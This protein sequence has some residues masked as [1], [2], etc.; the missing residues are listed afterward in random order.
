MRRLL[1]TPS[2]SGGTVQLPPAVEALLIDVAADGFALYCCGDK[3]APRALVASYEWDDCVD[4]ITI[5][6]FDT[7]TAAR[8]PSRGGVDI[9]APQ[10][11]VG[12]RRPTTVSPARVAGPRAPG[13]PRRT[14]H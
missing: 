9:F 8:V 1:S 13:A 4:L 3:A 7:I 12:L 2:R 10:V 5:R 14:L 6:D 11:V